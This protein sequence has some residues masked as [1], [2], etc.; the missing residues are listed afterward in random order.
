MLMPCD[1]SIRKFPWRERFASLYTIYTSKYLNEDENNE[2]LQ[3]RANSSRSSEQLLELTDDAA[4]ALQISR[5]GF[6]RQAIARHLALFHQRDDQILR[7]LF[8]R[9][10]RSGE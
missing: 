3:K 2:K 5:L 10:P 8:E 1:A 4:K 7:S 9:I 6:I